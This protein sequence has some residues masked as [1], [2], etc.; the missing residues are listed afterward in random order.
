M[1]SGQPRVLTEISVLTHLGRDA[2]AFISSISR[3][4][5]RRIETWTECQWWMMRLIIGE[6]DGVVNTFGC[7][8]E[9][10][11]AIGAVV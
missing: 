3:G 9:I 4:G 1:A 5:C 7:L 6:N 10:Q 8:S 11:V 2:A